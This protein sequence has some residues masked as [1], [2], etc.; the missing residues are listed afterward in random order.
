M[1]FPKNAEFGLCLVKVSIEP[2]QK[3]LNLDLLLHFVCIVTL[4]AIYFVKLG[5]IIEHLISRKGNQLLFCCV[6]CILVLCC[7]LT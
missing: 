6:N 5:A 7:L 3:L 4:L 2:L 1:I